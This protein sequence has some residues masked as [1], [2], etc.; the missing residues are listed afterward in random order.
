MTAI[1]ATEIR[2][3]QARAR[4]LRGVTIKSFTLS[5]RVG[6]TA[7]IASVVTNY[8]GPISGRASRGSRIAASQNDFHSFLRRLRSFK[9]LS[10]L[11]NDVDHHRIFMPGIVMKQHEPFHIA[12]LSYA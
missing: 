3:T 1:V 9:A 8:F 4:R 5:C 10:S 11:C 2:K 12:F 6:L 7:P